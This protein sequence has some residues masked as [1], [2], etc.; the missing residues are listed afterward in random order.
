MVT[1]RPGG[2]R[3]P[4]A[5]DVV[6]DP[7]RAVVE[8]DQLPHAGLLGQAVAVVH[9]GVAVRL[10]HGQLGG[11]ELR[12]VDEDVGVAGQ[13]EDRVVDRAVAV[14]ARAQGQWAVVRGV[15]HRGPAGIHDA[16]AERAAALV[17][18]L[19]GGDLEALDEVLALLQ[20][21]EG[22]VPLQALGPDREV[23]GR[24]RAGQHVDRGPAV[25]LVGYEEPDLG[26]GLVAGA[27]EGQALGVVPVQV[28]QEQ[29][30]PEGTAVEAVGQ[31]LQ[32]GAGVEHQRRGV[33]PRA[34]E[35]DTGR[36]APDAHEVG[37]RG[38]RRPTDTA[39]EDVHYG[40]STRLPSGVPH[41]ARPA[42]PDRP[43]RP[44]RRRPGSGSGP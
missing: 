8:E 20:G 22:P 18:Q 40:R 17:G 1:S 12:V 11:D 19:D 29:R 41:S 6:V 5:V 10:G 43:G 15:D 23:R 3:S 21:G 44:W 9:R 39:E 26:V 4:E 35:R 14:L 36:V 13:V 16:V 30:A 38:R 7:H 27:E 28:G 37:A 33:R 25:L 42:P 34:R 24:H 2:A 32:P 31:P